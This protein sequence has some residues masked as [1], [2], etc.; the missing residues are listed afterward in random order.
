M[1]PLFVADVAVMVFLLLPYVN[2]RLTQGPSLV[3]ESEIRGFVS[4]Q[5]AE[6]VTQAE[7]NQAFLNNFEAYTNE[8][9]TQL[10]R[11]S[12]RD[13]GFASNPPHLNSEAVYVE[14]NGR[15]LAVIRL[16]T[17]V[18]YQVVILGI[19]NEKREK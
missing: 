1:M 3:N 19:V 6:G 13:A 10:A 12:L 18:D 9:I 7:M 11:E 17:T 2:S 15:K 16:W 4:S 8:R 5:D 14:S